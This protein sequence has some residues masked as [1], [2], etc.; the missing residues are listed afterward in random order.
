MDYV[1]LQNVYKLNQINEGNGKE[2]RRWKGERG[3]VACML[4]GAAW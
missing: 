1:L 4:R 2:R 3:C